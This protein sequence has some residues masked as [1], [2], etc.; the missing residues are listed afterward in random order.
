MRFPLPLLSCLLLLGVST[1]AYAE[2]APRVSA[3]GERLEGLWSGP[4]QQV[5]E[6][7][8]I[9]FA[10]PPVG[11]ARW[12]APRPHLPRKGLQ[13]ATSFAPACM[14]GTRMV[15]WYAGVAKTFGHGPDVVE[16]PAA[17]SEDCLY[18]NVWSPRLEPGAQLPVLVFVHGGSNSGGWSYE[19]NY[20]GMNLAARGAVVITV[21][22]RLGPFGFFSHPALAADP[23]EAQANFALLDLRAAFRWVQANVSVFG[24]DP[25]N[26]AAIGESAG[27]LNLVDLMLQDAFTG[28]GRQ[29]LFR[30]VISQSIGGSLDERQTLAMERQRGEAVIASL[31]LADDL[32]AAMLRRIPAVDLLEAVNTLPVGDYH[33]AV[34]D[35]RTLFETP[36]VMA[37]KAD[38]SSVEM[39]LG[40]NADEWLMYIDDDAGREEL[41]AW[42]DENAPDARGALLREYQENGDARRT[43]DRLRTA[44]NMLC[45]SHDLAQRVSSAGGRAY[46]YYF[47][48]QR[49]GQGGE[50]LGAYHG[51]ELPYVFDRHDSWMP[52]AAEDRALTSAMTDYWLQFARSGNP[53]S[54]GR[55]SWP[56]YSRGGH[57]VM[58][59]DDPLGLMP[60]DHDALC[61]V[62][63]TDAGFTE[64][65]E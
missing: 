47:S 37:R 45:P 60:P 48:R 18:L 19:P 13:L 39:V 25:G 9:P 62:L 50:L 27:A 24:G 22:Y 1:A 7:R 57:D 32:S 16:K 61:S 8:G 63:G 33:D 64:G 35:G 15:D 59:L 17:V 56:L 40:T 44:K 23:D 20:L 51:A 30:R 6:F 26:I 38:L 11:E 12:R 55:L 58:R 49:E 34:I 14:Q 29:S 3:N 36:L 28:R 42:I 21:A 54:V 41:L 10:E 46:L 4:G 53:N 5:A 2:K 43:L 65:T 31:G 52:L